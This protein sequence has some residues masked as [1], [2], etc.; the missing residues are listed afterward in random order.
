[1]P[2]QTALIEIPRAASGGGDGA[3]EP[4]HRVLRGRVDRVVRHRRQPGERGGHDDPPARGHHARE[5]PHPEHDA[6]D[7]DAHR[8]AVALEGDLGRVG[9]PAED[10][11]VEAGDLDRADRVPVVGL[12]D[13][14]A[15]REVEDLDLD[16][17]GR[18]RATIAAPMPEAPPVTIAFIGR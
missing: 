2:G 12:G 1:M 4:D 17:L 15:V 3:D 5:P 18:S 14:E 11:G 13:V 16:L 6:V 7:V 9:R 8:L 10:A